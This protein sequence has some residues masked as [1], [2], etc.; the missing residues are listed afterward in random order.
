MCTSVS[1]DYVYKYTHGM[2]NYQWFYV[3]ASVYPLFK[4]ARLHFLSWMLPS[5]LE[6]SVCRARASHSVLSASAVFRGLPKTL[7]L[8]FTLLKCPLRGS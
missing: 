2:C 6:G 8:V 1:R 5:F 7:P 3:Y 4:G